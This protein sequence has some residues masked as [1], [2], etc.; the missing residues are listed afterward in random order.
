MKYKRIFL[1]ILDSLGVGEAIDAEEYNDRETNT[2]GH[3]NDNTNLFIPNLKKLGLLNTLT[4]NNVEAD[5]YYTIA[6]PKNKGKDCVSA[7][8]ELMGISVD[9]PFE[10]FNNG[11]FPRELLENIA[12]QTEKPIIGNII[13]DTLN[14][15]KKLYKRQIE[16]KSLIIYTTGD[17]NLEVA[18]DEDTISL[19]ELYQT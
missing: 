8:Y 17:G 2:L 18:A 13:C 6:R 9:K 12:S 3:I 7:H 11:P 1:L 16:T 15:I 4:M 5:A 14:A 19:N 10:N